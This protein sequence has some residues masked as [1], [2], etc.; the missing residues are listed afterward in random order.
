MIVFNSIDQCLHQSPSEFNLFC[1]EQAQL[2]SL[3]DLWDILS[4]NSANS[5]VTAICYSAHVKYYLLFYYL[6]IF[7][8]DFSD[9]FF[10]KSLENQLLKHSF[11]I[12]PAEELHL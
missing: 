3:T 7:C 9:F 10:V 5:A 11:W 1:G 8:M 2:L 12:L 6:F 4:S